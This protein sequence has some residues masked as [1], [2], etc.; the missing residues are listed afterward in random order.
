MRKNISDTFPRYVARLILCVITIGGFIACSEEAAI[1]I[2]EDAVDVDD[3]LVQ[4]ILNVGFALEHIEKSTLGYLVEGDILFPVDY[5]LRPILDRAK[6]AQARFENIVDI[7]RYN[8]IKVY[9][10][11]SGFTDNHLKAVLDDAIQLAINAFNDMDM[12]ITFEEVN[13]PFNCPFG[14]FCGITLSELDIALGACGAAHPPSLSGMPGKNVYIS[15][16][17]LMGTGSP[18]EGQG[19]R[20][21]NNPNNLTRLVAHELGHAIGLRHT[22]WEPR[23]NPNA[24]GETDIPGTPKVDPNSVMNSNGGC[25]QDWNGFSQGDK[26]ALK[27]LYGN[28][29]AQFNYPSTGGFIISQPFNEIKVLGNYGMRNAVLP[30]FNTF[31]MSR[32][33]RYEV[34]AVLPGGFKLNSQTGAIG[35]NVSNSYG[36]WSRIVTGIYADGTESSVTVRFVRGRLII[37]PI[38]IN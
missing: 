31:S 15:Q 6:T 32:P 12:G 30:V 34:N 29:G 33:V 23:E 22:N 21:T 17:N 3:P 24:N 7:T 11:D 2:Q 27:L 9:F 37:I 10:D 16:V 38:D 13:R 25:F 36:S 4:H 26:E 28:D 18:F 20:P 1:E 35:A 8:H 19:T 5:E 14:Q